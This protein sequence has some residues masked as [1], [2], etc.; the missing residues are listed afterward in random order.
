MDTSTN[1][2]NNSSP[3]RLVA[4]YLPQF[5]PIP[6]NDQWWGK[7]FTE[8]TNVGKAT[9]LFKGHYQP[10]V[11]ADL[12][13]YDLRLKESRCAQAEMAQKYG[14]E[15]FCYWHY[16]FGEGKRLLEMPFN[17]ALNNDRT[18]LSFCLGW[19]NETWSG[20]WH[21]AKDKV[22][23]E[24]KYL[25]RED[26][27][28]HYRDVSKAF[29]DRRYFKV[30]NKPLFL[31]YKPMQIPDPREFFEVWNELAIKDGL[32]GIYFVAQ[33]TGM[34]DYAKLLEIGFDAVNVVR[35]YDYE[36]VKHSKVRRGVKMLLNELRL[37][38]YKDA[39][40]YFTGEEDRE[41]TC[42]PTLIPNWD[43]SPRSNRRG[44]ILHDSRPEYF[45]Q[46][47]EMVLNNVMHK[48]ADQRIAFIKSW[49]EWGE[50][51]YMEPD[52][53]HGLGYLEALKKGLEKYS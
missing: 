33:T 23:I 34:K 49:N 45:A 7:G 48:P 20:I 8:W 39:M 17:E 12:G 9:P 11:P 24:Q 52:I 2:I 13:Y 27:I 43:H 50:G 10:R 53:I 3:V 36:K 51:N 18:T 35:L 5:H 25:G 14:I 15:A 40:Q 38:D 31:V 29:F 30:T 32:D 44:Y 22:L 41:I 1:A 26:Y 47:L 4:S 37:Y 16:W 42:V 6:E 19:A 28:R 46:H 21:G